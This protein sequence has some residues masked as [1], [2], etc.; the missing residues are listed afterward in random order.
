MADQK[1]DVNGEE[2]KVAYENIKQKYGELQNAYKK[3]FPKVDFKLIEDLLMRSISFDKNEHMYAINIITKTPIDTEAARNFFL[4]KI[5]QVPSSYE[6]GTHYLVNTK[7]T[8]A[9]LYDIQS[10]DSVDKIYGDYEGFTSTV[11][12]I[13]EHRGSNEQSRISNE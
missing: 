13:Y 1:V 8:F 7:A 3:Y 9:F 4:E 6:K 12:N 2:V 11:G 5:D 10:F